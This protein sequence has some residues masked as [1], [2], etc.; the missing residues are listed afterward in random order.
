MFLSPSVLGED[1]C[2]YLI[3]F[4]LLAI[5]ANDGEAV[6]G[7]QLVIAKGMITGLIID[8]S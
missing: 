2:C 5:T 4:Y 3:H 7:A 8:S 6:P 1:D